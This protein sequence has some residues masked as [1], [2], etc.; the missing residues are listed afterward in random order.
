MQCNDFGRLAV[1]YA[2]DELEPAEREAVEQHAASCASCAASLVRERRLIEAVASRLPAEP[3]AVFLAQCRGELADVLDDSSHLSLWRRFL[4]WLRP[5]SWFAVRPAWSAAFCIMLGITLGAML[6]RWLQTEAPM[7]AR[8]VVRASDTPGLS[9]DDFRKVNRIS[10]VPGGE[11]SRPGIQVHMFTQQPVVLTGTVDNS[12][13]RRLLMYVV[14]NNQQFDSGL[15]MDS[16]EALRALSDDAEVRGA[17]CYAARNDRNP[18]L[19]LKALE[20][21]RGFQREEQVH[22]TLLDALLRDNNPGVRVEAINALRAMADQ[23]E[24]QPDAELVKVLRDRMRNDPNSYVRMQSAAAVRQLGP[25][26]QY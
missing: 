24:G 5:N 22:K 2:C 9:A 21:L 25:R 17:L 7:T 14:Q 19:R 10:L 18:G 11:A 6:P 12:D 8:E 1:F 13:V 26:T 20:T 4:G 23:P 16:L 3:S 15:R